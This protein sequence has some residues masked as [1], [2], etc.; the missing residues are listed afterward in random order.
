V[1]V[2]LIVNPASGSAQAVDLAAT[3]AVF[4]AAGW[5]V[6]VIETAAPGDATRAAAAAVAADA[7]LVIASGGDGTVNEALQPIVGTRTALGVLPAGTANLLAREL[8]LPLRASEAARALV[9][10]DRRIVDVGVAGGQRYF[11]LF[12][13]VGFDAAVIHAVDEELKRAVG[14]LSF[15]AAA[16]RVMPRYRGA[17]AELLLDERRLRRHVLM[18]VVSNTRLFALF[19]L[20]PEAQAHDGRLDVVVFHGVGW[21]AKLRHLWSVLVPRQAAA[22]NIDR[23][24][25]RA[26]EVR[27]RQPL[28]VELDGELWG[29]T[30]MRFEVV[31]AA[32]TLWA[33][34]TAPEDLFGRGGRPD[35]AAG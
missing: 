24:R 1:R 6:D 15:V 3:V 12:A 21:W 4:R 20:A 13:G 34:P 7:D 17:P 9:A 19:P 25:V 30:P 22:P 29:E 8:R 32:A 28:P 26:I 27:G 11:L 35:A 2:L 14:A 5:A 18:V 31:P 16:A 23:A 33:P 10:G